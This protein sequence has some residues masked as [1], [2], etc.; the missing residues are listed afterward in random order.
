MRNTYNT[1]FVDGW[2]DIRRYR[3][4]LWSET[5]VKLSVILIAIYSFLVITYLSFY[6]ISTNISFLSSVLIY[7]IAGLPNYLFFLYITWREWKEKKLLSGVS[8]IVL[9]FLL[10]LIYSAHVIY[11]LR[12]FLIL[13]MVLLY[14]FSPID[15][16]RIRLKK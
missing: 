5:R 14:W 11:I 3:K 6:I 16:V 12:I 15:L 13:G 2:K 10:S 9:F 8:M 4:K 1:R 7:N